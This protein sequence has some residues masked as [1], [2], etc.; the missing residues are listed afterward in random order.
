MSARHWHCQVYLFNKRIL[1][2]VKYEV[3][4]CSVFWR[5]ISVVCL[6]AQTSSLG[7]SWN[8][9]VE[10]DI[11]GR[12]IERW[13]DDSRHYKDALIPQ[14]QIGLQVERIFRKQYLIGRNL[15]QE[16]TMTYVTFWLEGVLL[17]VISVFG[18]IGKE[19]FFCAV[20]ALLLSEAWSRYYRDQWSD[21]LL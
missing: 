5:A 17:P 2:S 16:E 4:S 20:V 11:R 18:L 9:K 21:I 19:T 1:S 7:S 8:R 15:N 3:C 13:C 12:Q 10:E 14:S 6:L